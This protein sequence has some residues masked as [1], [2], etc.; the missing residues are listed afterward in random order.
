[1]TA[2]SR[3]LLFVWPEYPPAFGGMQVHGVEIARYL[4]AAGI[5][6]VVVTYVPTGA[7]RVRA[8][9][10][11]E[12]NPFE[13]RRILPRGS[14][15]AVLEKLCKLRDELSPTVVFSSQAAFAPVFFPHIR[16]VC[17]SAGNDVLR[18]WIGPRN[19]SSS[20][21]RTLPEKE[22]DDRLRD[23][24]KWV[25]HAL[26]RCSVVLCNS[27]WTATQVRALGCFNA[28]VILGGVDTERFRQFSRDRIRACF[29]NLR[30]PVAVIAARHVKKKGIDTALRALPLVRNDQLQLL[31]AGT[32]PESR[33][34][35]ELVIQL[36]LHRRVR[37]VG[38]LPH[39][40][41][42]YLIGLSDIVLVPSRSVFDERRGA[43]DY[44]TMGR[45]ACEAAACGVPV[46]ASRIG[47]LPEVVRHGETGI[48]VQ[49][50]DPIELAAAV[51]SILDF[52][53]SAIRMGEAARAF[54]VT[55]LSF[56][57]VGEATL[58]CLYPGSNA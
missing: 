53:T 56:N 17:R 19:V 12:A 44:E 43:V 2:N 33:R 21:L 16:F 57:A 58:D 7:T 23:N 48:L 3:R 37:F 41:L 50:D 51:D 25:H 38:P 29:G 35:R 18:P 54:A 49:P 39:D 28:R 42:P 36:G 10:I 1:M 52:P 34:L 45:I 8:A 55:K 6:L 9:E 26:R 13:T 47:G 11:D 14:F 5:Q 20:V 32:G 27:E 22:I 4:Q 30:G 15:S 46:V 31:I 24:R 40:Q